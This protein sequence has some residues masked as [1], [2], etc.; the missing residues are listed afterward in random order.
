MVVGDCALIPNRGT[1]RHSGP[2]VEDGATFW[3]HLVDHPVGVRFARRWQ[4]FCWQLQGEVSSAGGHS[5]TLWNGGSSILPRVSPAAGLATTV[6]AWAAAAPANRPATAQRRCSASAGIQRP[7]LALALADE[8]A[9]RHHVVA[10]PA[11]LPGLAGCGQARSCLGSRLHRLDRFAPARLR[12]V[13]V[14][15]QALRMATLGP[16]ASWCRIWR[17][18]QN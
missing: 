6:R 5:T 2:Q 9:G 14:G 13:S 16:V 1:K 10:G 11:G 8:Q 4:Q 18:S 3:M 17:H 12:K 15:K 7:V